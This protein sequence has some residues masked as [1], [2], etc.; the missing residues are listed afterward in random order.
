MEVRELDDLELESGLTLVLGTELSSLG[1]Q[2]ELSTTKPS[3]QPQEIFE[4]GNQVE[5]LF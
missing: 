1:Q 2:Q 5:K 4:Y 3:L